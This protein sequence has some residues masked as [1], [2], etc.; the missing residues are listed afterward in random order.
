MLNG[1]CPG[2]APAP[3]AVNDALVVDPRG[4]FDQ[5]N[6]FVR[7]AKNSARGVPNR[8]RGGRAPRAFSIIEVLM[9][10]SLLSLI[11]LALME[12]FSTT[13]RAFRAGVTQSDVLEGGRAAVDLITSD[14]RQMAP[15]GGAVNLSVEGNYWYDQN[16][17]LPLLQ[18]LP[19][20]STPIPTPGTP[21]T[22]T[23]TNLLEAV[24][25]I[26]R[27]NTTWVGTGYF[28]NHK[29]SSPLYPLYRFTATTSSQNNVWTLQTNFVDTI[30]SDLITGVW[31]N[32]SHV[33]DGVV[34]FVV[35]P[36]DINGYQIT[37]T[38]QYES[39][40]WVTNQDVTFFPPVYGE[41]GFYFFSNTV[42]AS[43][44]LEIGVL[45]DRTLQRAASRP[46]AV[47][48]SQYLADKS[49][50]VHLFRQRVTIPNVDPTAYQ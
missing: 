26:G 41:T 44:E 11:V 37:S 22:V 12:V 14:L 43:V 40:Q 21:G 23:R 5:I 50:N 36:Y 38:N 46:T 45:E 48:R 34:H 19:P 47:L 25:F 8:T 33:L 2:S 49:G 16:Y 20:V 27:Q 15:S 4:R 7:C 18:I 35:R 30:S 24:F 1:H 17:Y 39:G 10:I 3:G 31:T 42:P 32:M 28:V 29:S 9:V 13:Q 6:L